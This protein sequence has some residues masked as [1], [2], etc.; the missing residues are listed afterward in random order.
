MSPITRLI[1]EVIAFSTE[2]FL[3]G[4]SL[5]VFIGYRKSR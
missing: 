1:A 3:F 4:M 2:L 5:Y